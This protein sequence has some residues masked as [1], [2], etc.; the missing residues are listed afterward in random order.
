MAP[1]RRY[2]PEIDGIRAIAV[3]SVIWFHAGLPA[4]P[5]GFL[6][7]DV[8]FAI[9]GFLITGII[10]RAGESGQ[11]SL[12]QF[13]MRR[14]RRIIPALVVAAAL[15]LPLAWWLMLPDDLENYG[16][17]LVATMA[18]AN[19]VLLY[20]TSGYFA[21]E[22]EYKPLVHIWSLGAEE[23]YY[24]IVPLLLALALR[25]G[26]R[27]AAGIMLAVLSLAS[28]G[29]AEW[30]RYADPDANFYLLPSRFWELGLGGVAAIWEIRLRA[31]VAAP[32]QRQGLA[33]LGLAMLV[34][35]LFVLGQADNLP[36]WQSLLPVGGTV[37]VLVFADAT[38]AGRVL[39]AAP[40]RWVGLISYSAYLYHQPVFAFVRIA[41]LD[42]P[43]PWLMAA[44][45][46]AILLLAWLSWRYVEQPFRDPARASGRR[47]LAFAVGGS[48]L[49]AAAGAALT[50][51]SGL[52]AQWPELAEG[53]ALF[54]ARQS[55][56]YIQRPLIHQD[57]PFPAADR[58]RNLLVIGSSFARDF[59]NMG[60]ETG[61][62]EG[63]TISYVD[64]TPCRDKSPPAALFA[65]AQKAGAV[66]LGSGITGED[67]ACIMDLVRQFE[68]AGAAHVVVLGTKNFGFNNNAVM[69][70]PE[71]RRYAFR[72][73]PLAEVAADNAAARAAIPARYY[74]DLLALMDDGSGT[75]PV[76]T[77]ERKFIS[78]DRRHLTRPGAAWL[79]RI[80]FAQ[81]QFAF[82]RA[83]PLAAPHRTGHPAGRAP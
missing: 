83:R 11:F 37:L 49:L 33:A 74:V 47:V 1:D 41:S 24:V 3:L 40:M 61:A 64:F 25:L 4:M 53:E 66:V 38:G 17:S 72:A 18:S 46:P 69:L 75:V 2:R 59:I 13:Y 54:G 67:P 28:L 56:E 32:L 9:S 30:L 82:L 21:L 22:S 79:G 14:I 31:A 60:H 80:V 52:R 58:S 71:A 55:G 65:R 7:V 62:F 81:P 70:L 43:S 45:V 76:F 20:L 73:R 19:N 5:G 34:A 27:A 44:T 26:G 78:Q 42:R 77:P 48:A 63:L 8:F 16:Q 51:T 29:L 15:T 12:G 68:G 39:A 36:G 57:Q 23:Q 6:G 10:V 50:A 35:A